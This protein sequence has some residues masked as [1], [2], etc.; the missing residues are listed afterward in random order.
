MKHVELKTYRDG[1]TAV[2]VSEAAWRQLAR[3]VH[4][5]MGNG[6]EFDSDEDRQAAEA[7][8]QSLVGH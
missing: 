5:E 8:R 1:R 7:L 4:L 3:M 6:L 2:V